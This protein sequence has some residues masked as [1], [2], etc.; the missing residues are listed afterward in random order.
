MVYCNVV[1]ILID[2]G[3]DLV[4]WNIGQVILLD[5]GVGAGDFLVGYLS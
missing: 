1:S 3:G 5:L 4:Y 2:L